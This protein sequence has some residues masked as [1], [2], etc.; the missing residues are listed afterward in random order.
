MVATSVRGK[1]RSLTRK[2]IAFGRLR[3]KR[4]VDPHHDALRPFL[5]HARRRDGVLRLQRSH[6]RAGFET[7]CRHLPG[8]KFEKNHFILRTENVDLADIGDGQYL[9][10]DFFDSIAQLTMAQAVAGESINIA[11][12]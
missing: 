6:Y 3:R 10:A 4:T 9:R 5:E 8:G 2:L 11:V 7:K 12:Y 1:N